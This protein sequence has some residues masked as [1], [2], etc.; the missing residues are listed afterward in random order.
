MATY[1]TD[2]TVVTV[3]ADDRVIDHGWVSVD[4]STITGLGSGDAPAGPDDRVV[5]GEGGLVTPGL[6]STHDHMVDTL[7]RGGKIERP[8]S[9]AA[10]K[11]L[12]ATAAAAE[13]EDARKR[14]ASILPPIKSPEPA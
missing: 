5:G 6:V 7:L 14:P 4:G 8:I 2:V 3:D 1:L 13:G 10:K 12:E 9:A 11:R